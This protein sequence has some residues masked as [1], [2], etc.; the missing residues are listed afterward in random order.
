MGCFARR[1]DAARER[2]RESRKENG[3]RKEAGR[4]RRH[5]RM[6]DLTKKAGKLSALTPTVLSWLSVELDKPA[7]R[8]TQEDLDA[9]TKSGS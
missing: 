4:E 8:I 1:W 7:T 2:A 6:I 3:F 9:I 5:A